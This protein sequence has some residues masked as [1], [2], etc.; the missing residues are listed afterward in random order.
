MIVA[1]IP[2]IW[3]RKGTY[4]EISVPAAIVVPVGNRTLAEINNDRAIFLVLML[5]P[6][7]QII[8]T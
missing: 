7:S 3:V 6:T 4:P 2:S 1:L 8:N 5:S